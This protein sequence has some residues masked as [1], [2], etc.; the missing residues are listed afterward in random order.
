MS[1]EPKEYRPRTERRH[2]GDQ[3]RDKPEL[4]YS[5][6]T[7]IPSFKTLKSKA[8]LVPQNPHQNLCPIPSK[9]LPI[10][11]IRKSEVGN[12]VNRKGEITDQLEGHEKTD[13]S[14]PRG[15]SGISLL[16]LDQRSKSDT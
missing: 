11:G 16:D 6:G 14:N 7:P 4:V 12:K 2:S 8:K 13:K 3:A 10:K 5:T 1:K 15:N 9:G